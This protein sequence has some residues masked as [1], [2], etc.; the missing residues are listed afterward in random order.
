MDSKLAQTAALLV[1]DGKGL[2][3]ADESTG[4]IEKRFE[5]V[6][7][8]S[9]EESRRAWRELLF[10]TAGLGRTISGVILFDETIRERASTGKTMVELLTAEGILPG[11][12]VDRGTHPLAG[13]DGELVTEGL[14]GLRAR[15]DEYAALGAR[16]SKWRAELTIT[17]RG[18]TPY[19]IHVN[20]HALARYAAISQAAGIVPIVEP[21]VMM[22]G[23]H[24]IRR[25]FE[26]TEAVHEAL[27]EELV[28]QRVVLEGCLLK[29]NMVL[30]GKE[31][32]KRASPDE[33]A[34][35]SLRCFRR[36]VPAAVPGI[37]FLSGGQEDEESV[38]NLDAIGRLVRRRAA[39]WPL[40]FSYGRGLESEPM[41]AWAG[42][43]ANKA[44]AQAA[45][46]H[47][48]RLTS[49]ASLGQYR[50]AR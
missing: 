36:T 38:V 25:C 39:P 44:A 5:S 6:G 29:T 9:T 20:A 4:T 40:T 47:R 41:R 31:A 33:V 10:T 32:A 15:F 43:S 7:I 11:I 14:D 46:L 13:A 24:D 45:L 2:L 42:Q 16:F 28:R 22:E 27:F 3:A 18:P 37:V 34:E 19:S 50:D 30:S 12:K 35:E 26:V 23:G 1:A 17:D 49:L 21:E 48:A 8:V